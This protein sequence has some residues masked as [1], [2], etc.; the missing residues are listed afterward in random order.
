M[1]ENQTSV[2]DLMEV[3]TAAVRVI[4]DCPQGRPYLS[5]DHPTTLR[6]IINHNLFA[7]SLIG[8]F[9]WSGP[10]VHLFHLA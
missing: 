6:M 7:V 3:D 8:L 5:L 2:V 9:W 1:L 4:Y 10:W